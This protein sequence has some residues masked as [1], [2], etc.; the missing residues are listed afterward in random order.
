[1]TF[2]TSPNLTWAAALRAVIARF[3]AAGLD[4]PD[5]DARLLLA[6]VVGVDRLKLI[7][8][9]DTRLTQL[10][11]AA[12]EVV[13]QRRLTR[14]PV[15]RILGERWFFGR[16]FQI[17]PATLDP[18]PD[19]ETLVE[20]VLAFV[21]AHG[22][23]EE[24]LR[25]LDIGTGSGCLLLSLLAEMPQA[26]GVGTDISAAAIEIA[27]KN[28]RELGVSSDRVAWLLGDQLQSVAGIFNI[29]LSNPPYIPRSEIG[30]LDPEV[31][32]FDPAGALDGG[33][34]GLD[35]YRSIIR[36]CNNYI[37]KSNGYIIFEIGSGQADAVAKLMQT[38]MRVAA[39]EIE[40]YVDLG[41][42][43]RCVAAST[44]R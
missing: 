23:Q 43:V 25:L 13:V 32:L 24:P 17:S 34:D 10:Q 36:E 38:E 37:C 7:S 42:V 26:T 2:A 44:R 19:S 30:N 28:A 31:R 39:N 41:H 21:A 16:R 4:T 18:R 12:L 29:I 9:A 35:F 20:A 6:S 14:E 8:E 5:T 11:A 40:T 22:L 27:R 3:K 15:S 33:Q 1:M